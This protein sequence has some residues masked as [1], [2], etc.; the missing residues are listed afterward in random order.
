[1][2]SLTSH[3]LIV[4]LGNPG[5]DYENTRHN[6]GFMLVDAAALRWQ[7]GPFKRKFQGLMGEGRVRDSRVTLLKPMTFMNAS[8]ESVNLARQYLK[9]SPQ[10]VVVCVDDLALSLG[11][12]RLR[13]QGSS[14]GHNGLKSIIQQLG[15]EV[16][17]RLRIGIGSDFGENKDVTRHVLGVFSRAEREKVPSILHRGIDILELILA[18]GCERAMNQANQRKI[19]P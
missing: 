16:F 8:G 10:N 14:G 12:F 6:L 11:R 1:M 17:P 3:W 13:L 15:S 5:E 7:I 19:D 18:E 9:V 4:G 2:A